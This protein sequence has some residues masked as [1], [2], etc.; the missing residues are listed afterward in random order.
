MT[1][2]DDDD[3]MTE[4]AWRKFRGY[5]DYLLARIPD[6]PVRTDRKLILY[7]CACCQRVRALFP[8]DDFRAVIDWA[9]EQVD[10][11]PQGV[12]TDFKGKEVLYHDQIEN[13]VSGWQQ[14]TVAY[15]LAWA[16]RHLSIMVWVD[17]GYA[18]HIGI[19]DLIEEAVWLH[20]CG[21]SNTPSVAQSFVRVY[22]DLPPGAQAER[23]AQCEFVR[24]IFG[25]LPFRPVIVDPSWLT[26]TVLSLAEGIYA[27]HAFDRLPI[28]ADALQDAGCNNDDILSHCRSDG[29]H[30]R[31]CWV[32]DLILAKQ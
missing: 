17:N 5:P 30:V 11:W 27:D 29:P 23:D 24:D 1:D 18:G 16:A 2:P 32:V 7:V 6:G 15:R 13:L 19:P 26:P 4:D 14:D 31:G 21:K 10:R 25:P 28:L 20:H 22:I 9:E 3:M 8:S 12:L